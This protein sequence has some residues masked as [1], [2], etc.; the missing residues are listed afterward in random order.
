MITRTLLAVTVISWMATPV[1]AHA[2]LN[3]A[4]PGAGA[5]LAQ[6]PQEIALSFTEKLEPTSSGMSISD[7]AGHDMEAAAPAI[8]GNTV[9]VALKPLAA[10]TYRVSWHAVSLDS[11]RTEGSYSFSVVPPG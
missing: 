1:L 9:T 6:A 5:T 8:S 7:A 4:E 3:H 2:F 11:H 10:G